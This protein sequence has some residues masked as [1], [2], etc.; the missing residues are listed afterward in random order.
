[1]C[2]ASAEDRKAQ[3]RRQRLLLMN[4]LPALMASTPAGRYKSILVFCTLYLVG[5]LLATGSCVPGRVSAPLLFPSMYILALG[6]GGIKSSV[7]VFGADQFDNADPQDAVEKE[8]FFN[9]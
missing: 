9:W 2:K 5:L 8:S 3:R 4:F 7:S 6:T 1:M